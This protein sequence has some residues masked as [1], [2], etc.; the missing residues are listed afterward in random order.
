MEWEAADNPET[1]TDRQE[2]SGDR[3]KGSRTTAPLRA[4]SQLRSLAS[5]YVLG[6][7]IILLP[8]ITR[9]ETQE[10]HSYSTNH[11]QDIFFKELE[12]LADSYGEWLHMLLAVAWL[13]LIRW[14]MQA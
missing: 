6:M 9:R 11:C 2:G 7:S 14:C 5:A 13:V 8:L 10:R 3:L 1:T 12:A 4:H